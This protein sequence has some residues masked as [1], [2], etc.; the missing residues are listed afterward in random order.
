MAS[1]PVVRVRSVASVFRLGAFLPSLSGSSCVIV[2]LAFMIP[3][4]LGVLVSGVSHVQVFF[5]ACWPG[6]SSALYVEPVLV[7]RDHDVNRYTCFR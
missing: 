1:V 3:L 5:R 7:I 2:V 4:A 6:S